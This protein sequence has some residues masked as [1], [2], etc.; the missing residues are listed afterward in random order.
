MYFNDRGFAKIT[1][2]ACRRKRIYD[3]KEKILKREI[4]RKVAQMKRAA[5]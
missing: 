4:E 2:G 5:R 1:L 3:K